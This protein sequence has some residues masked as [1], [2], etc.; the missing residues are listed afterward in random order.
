MKTPLNK[1]CKVT[2][3]IVLTAVMLFGITS[4]AFAQVGILENSLIE[5]PKKNNK[6]KAMLSDEEK[7]KLA[8]ALNKDIHRK[9]YKTEFKKQKIHK[10]FLEFQLNGHPQDY[11][12][13]IAYYLAEIA[14]NRIL[15]RNIYFKDGEGLAQEFKRLGATEAKDYYKGFFDIKAGFHKTDKVMKN[16]HIA[17]LIENEGIIGVSFIDGNIFVHKFYR[18][19]EEEK[20]VEHSY[21]FPTSWCIKYSIATENLYPN[22]KNAHSKLIKPL[23]KAGA[24]L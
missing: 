22:N 7:Q 6:T 4:H 14:D 1:I 8:D 23:K 19:C 18:V 2:A 5:V 20:L 16:V 12:E 13:I 15:N 17:L 3:S 10:A 11:Y 21:G 24:P 9:I